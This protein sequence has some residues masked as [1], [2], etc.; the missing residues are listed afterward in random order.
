M[1]QSTLAGIVTAFGTMFTAVALIITAVAGLIRARRVERK[2][3]TVHKI[4][5]QQHTDLK[6]YQRALIAALTKAGIDVPED[7]SVDTTQG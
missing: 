2:V 5:N 4:V 7:Q 3:D 1:P 6:N